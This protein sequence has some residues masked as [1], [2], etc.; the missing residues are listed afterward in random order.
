MI[1]IHFSVISQTFSILQ[2]NLAAILFAKFEDRSQSRIV[3][4]TIMNPAQANV[5]PMPTSNPTP[6]NQR[7]MDRPTRRFPLLRDGQSTHGS[8]SEHTMAYFAQVTGDERNPACQQCTQGLG[9]Y[10]SCVTVPNSFK[11][12]CGNCIYR[13]RRR[14]CSISNCKFQSPF[15]KLFL[16]LYE[17]SP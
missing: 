15:I 3:Y 5:A 11:G 2:I 9:P 1:C 17:L 12:V 13:G 7:L 10:I 16:A 6:M 4:R 8:R 14:G